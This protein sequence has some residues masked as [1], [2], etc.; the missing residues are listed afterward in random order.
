MSVNSLAQFCAESLPAYLVAGTVSSAVTS[1][2]AGVLRAVAGDVTSLIALQKTHDR[3]SRRTLED[4]AA[5][6]SMRTL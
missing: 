1:L 4:E 5:G 6:P 2:A 3:V